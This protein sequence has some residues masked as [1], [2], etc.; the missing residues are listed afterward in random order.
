MSKEVINE[1]ARPICERL[2]CNV[3]PVVDYEYTNDGVVKKESRE[4]YANGSYL[5][6]V[7]KRTGHKD[8][9]NHCMAMGMC[10][11]ADEVVVS[12]DETPRIENEYLNQLGL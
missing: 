2:E 4:L 7:P 10:A 5:G 8:V 11:E 9:V 3:V 1:Y 6:Q 12:F